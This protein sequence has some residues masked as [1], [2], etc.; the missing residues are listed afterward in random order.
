MKLA[1]FGLLAWLTGCNLY[2]PCCG[3]SDCGGGSI[4]SI[5]DD[6]CPAPGHPKGLCLT[7]CGIDRDCEDGYVCNVIILN[8]GCQAIGDGGSEGTCAPGVGE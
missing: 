3:N 5:D 1:C 4:C 8:C 7:K 6:K 2:G